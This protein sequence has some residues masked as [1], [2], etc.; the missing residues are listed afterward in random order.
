[1]PNAVFFN[2]YKLKTG[3]LA[4]EFLTSVDNLINNFM[5]KQKGFLSF[6]LLA[7]EDIWADCGIFETMEDAKNALNSSNLNKFAEVFCSFLDFDTCKSNIFSIEKRMERMTNVPNVVT[8]VSFKLKAKASIP[9]FL[10][11]KENIYSDYKSRDSL[12]M[13]SKL[14]LDCDLWADLLYW[15]SM[16]GPKDAIKSE[17]TKAVIKEYLSF[18]GEVSYQRHFMVKRSY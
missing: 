11:A 13:S 6:L 12:L 16:E 7:D 4:S 5:S 8:F 10:V 9:D 1:M 18:I 17:R 14:L 2:S 15:E 3:S